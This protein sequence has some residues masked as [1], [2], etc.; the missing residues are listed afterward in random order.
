[1]QVVY[2]TKQT[3]TRGISDIHIQNIIP[4][5]KVSLIEK[6]H[7]RTYTYSMTLVTYLTTYMMSTKVQKT[8]EMCFRDPPSELAP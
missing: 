7:S 2:C 5:G 1:M 8:R 3:L 4:L 6:G